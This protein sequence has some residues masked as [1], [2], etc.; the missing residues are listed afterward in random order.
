MIGPQV[1]SQ[2]DQQSMSPVCALC[3]VSHSHKGKVSTWQSTQACDVVS[4]YGITQNEVCWPCRD[5]MLCR[6]LG[7]CT[8]GCWNKSQACSEG[9]FRFRQW[10]QQWSLLDWKQHCIYIHL[11]CQYII[12]ILDN[13]V[14]GNFLC[15][16]F[17]FLTKWTICNSS[18][19]ITYLSFELFRCILVLI[20]L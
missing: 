10:E 5:D 2:Y 12:Y 16:R 3:E 15:Q 8:C 9:C 17:L 7:R 19:S 11:K 20:N 13:R 14:S 4:W 1:I 18:W 6:V